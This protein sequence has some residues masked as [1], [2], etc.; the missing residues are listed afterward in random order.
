MT[1]ESILTELRNASKHDAANSDASTI[2]TAG[3]VSMPLDHLKPSADYGTDVNN[4]RSSELDEYK[5]LESTLHL[6]DPNT[7]NWGRDNHAQF[8]SNSY[9]H[10]T[11]SDPTC[12]HF[13]VT[14]S[15]E[16]D[17]G[18]DLDD[19]DLLDLVSESEATLTSHGMHSSDLSITTGTAYEI[20]GENVNPELP[21][22][23]Q[24]IEAIGISGDTPRS[25]HAFVS[26]VTLKTRLLAATDFAGS[27]ETKKPIVRAPFPAFVRDRSPIIGLSS[28]NLLRTCFR[29]GEAVNQTCHAL[30]AGKEIIIELYARV[31]DSKRTDA[32]QLFTLCDLF[33][34][35]PPYIQG[36]YNAAIWNSVQLFEYDSRRLLQPGRIC[37]C[38]GTMKRDGKEWVLS[39]R[40]I[41]EATW[42]DVQWVEGIVNA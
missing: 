25:S 16:D 22:V 21:A 7:D 42:E 24:F 18:N 39:I 32:E 37:R 28:G 3:L 33:H 6:E 8:N 1:S 11:H 30:K 27:T 41:W 26:P 29:I 9:Q 34:A 36:R 5:Q 19:D 40:N 20:C 13:D 14:L 23:H 4:G 15:D 2:S 38:M 35:K 17:F 10:S 12:Q 31:L